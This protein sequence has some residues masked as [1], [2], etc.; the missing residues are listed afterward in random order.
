MIGK[1]NDFKIIFG[2]RKTKDRGQNSQNW[3]RLPMHDG[4]EP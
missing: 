4:G 2:S 1:P 3:L